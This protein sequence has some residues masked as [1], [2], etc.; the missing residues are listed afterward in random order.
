MSTLMRRL[1]TAGTAL[2]LLALPAQL[3]AAAS[4]TGKDVTP[5]DQVQFQQQKALA[6]MR[7][8]EERMYRLAQ[9]IRD[10]AASGVPVDQALET[11]AW[12]YPRE[13]LADAVRR[14][15][16]QLPRSQKRLPLA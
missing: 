10:L 7:E 2:V 6:H 13:H 4:I 1:L 16:A 15:Y 14:G 12:P 3:S 5:A 8:L 9:T 11:T